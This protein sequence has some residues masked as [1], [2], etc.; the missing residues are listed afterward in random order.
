[1]DIYGNERPGDSGR[2][3][4]KTP[5][6]SVVIP[7]HNCERFIGQTI[8]SV[9]GQSLNDLEVIV[10]DDGSVDGTGRLALRYGN[11]VRVVTQDNAGVCVARNRGIGEATG[12]Y[13]A[14]LDQDDYW[15]PDKLEQQVGL[16]EREADFGVA[17]TSFMPWEADADGVYAAPM[18]MD[19]SR[20]GEGIEE[21]FSGWIYHQFL[22]DCWMLT[23]TAVFR[24]EAFER[25]G[26]FDPSLPYGE[27]WD[28]WLRLSREYRFVKLSS[29]STLYRQHPGQGNRKVRDFDYRTDILR[30]AANR[31]G[32]CSPDGKCLT[33]RAF[34]GQLAKY[35]VD[36]A[37]SHARVGDKATAL[38]ALLRAG[39]LE[40]WNIRTLAYIGAVVL[41]WRPSW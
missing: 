39:A 28:L 37:F 25:C 34:Y 6:V 23:S 9:L 17:Y 13:I 4:A 38:G 36:F 2:V 21:A 19:R 3:S 7:A 22:L 24:K 11:P 1:M 26:T 8:E 41:G 5:L 31:W 16:L 14:L 29:A 40:P 15:F 27:D 30:R 10:V 35:H 18:S 12:L 33:R 32:L 20:F